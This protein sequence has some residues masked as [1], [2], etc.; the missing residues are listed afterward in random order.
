MMLGLGIMKARG[1]RLGSLTWDMTVWRKSSE[2][3]KQEV[4]SR[5]R[6]HNQWCHRRWTEN[7]GSTSTDHDTGNNYWGVAS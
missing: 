1:F 6:G 3:V 5:A 7:G 2:K 4:R